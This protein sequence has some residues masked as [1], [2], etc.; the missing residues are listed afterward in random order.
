MVGIIDT[1]H[2]WVAARG[3]GGGEAAGQQD[4][5]AAPAVHLNVAG[6]VN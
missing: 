2:S 4:T 3:P 1:K 5:C 6:L